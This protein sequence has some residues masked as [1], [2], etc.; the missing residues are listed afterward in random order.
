MVDKDSDWGHT[1]ENQ[2]IFTNLELVVI[3]CGAKTHCY[4]PVLTQEADFNA[5]DKKAFTNFSNLQRPG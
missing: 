4:F 3:L 5:R 2:Y 1:I